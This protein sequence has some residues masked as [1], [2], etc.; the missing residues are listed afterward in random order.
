MG[1][2]PLARIISEKIKKPLAKEILYGDLIDGGR[3]RVNALN[4]QLSIVI[5]PAKKTTPTP[6]IDEVLDEKPVE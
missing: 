3:V 1:A 2:R 6:T 5:T 4:G